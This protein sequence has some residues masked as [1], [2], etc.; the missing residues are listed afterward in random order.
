MFH[1]SRALIAIIALFTMSGDPS[2][3]RPVPLGSPLPHTKFPDPSITWAEGKW[4]AFATGTRDGFLHFQL[5]SS[6]D[7][8]AW[9]I[10][11]NPN[12][13]QY[14]PL[15]KVPSWVHNGESPETWAPDVV[16]LDDGTFVMYYSAK[17]EGTVATH[18]VSAA[19]SKDVR[20][21]Y[22]PLDHILI[23]PNN[24]LGAFDVSGSKG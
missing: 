2:N 20:G 23:C 4:W 9:H 17:K 14:D 7:Y 8:K 15:P 16:K 6:T 10:E 22:V 19:T 24:S 18:C 5:A 13:Q 21:P 3:A 11:R 12:G 1:P